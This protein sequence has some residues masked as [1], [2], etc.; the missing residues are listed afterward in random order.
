MDI[1][2]L[3]L[4]QPIGELSSSTTYLDFRLENMSNFNFQIKLYKTCFTETLFAIK[5]VKEG[6]STGTEQMKIVCNLLT[7][8]N[9]EVQSLQWFNELL[10]VYILFINNS[11]SWK[12]HILKREFLIIEDWGSSSEQT[13]MIFSAL[14]SIWNFVTNTLSFLFSVI[15]DNPS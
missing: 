9:N 7:L 13:K 3:F 10:V 14:N 2:S 4:Y 8:Q 5:F 15:I 12:W 11:N 1:L 6:K